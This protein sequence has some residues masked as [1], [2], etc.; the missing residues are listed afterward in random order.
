VKDAL[1]VLTY[2][3]KVARFPYKTPKNPEISNIASGAVVFTSNSLTVS[4]TVSDSESIISDTFAPFQQNIQQACLFIDGHPYDSDAPPCNPMTL[5]GVGT[6]VTATFSKT[7][8][9][10]G[11]SSGRHTV[12]L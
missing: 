5:S 6:A 11:L 9:D 10:L 8:S 2:A 1:K 3:A 4:A 12:F 7:V